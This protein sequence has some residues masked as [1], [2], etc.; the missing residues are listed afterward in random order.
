MAVTAI[1][2]W[3]CGF[4]CCTWGPLFMQEIAVL[5]Y[6]KK[7]S[8]KGLAALCG[9]S[10]LHDSDILY[11]RGGEPTFVRH[12]G[13]VIGKYRI[14]QIHHVLRVLALR[15]DSTELGSSKRKFASSTLE[16]CHMYDRHLKTLALENQGG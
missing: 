5:Y 9:V 10:I 15:A 2:G 6:K 11:Y 14:F 4:Y 1:C 13:V 8:L 16:M 3:T 12:E 7:I